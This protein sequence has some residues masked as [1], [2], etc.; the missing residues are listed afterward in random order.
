METRRFSLSA[1]PALPA[2]TSLCLGTFDGV[3]RGH[4]ALIRQAQSLSEGPVA[5]LLFDKSPAQFVRNGKS[6]SLLTTLADKLRLFA[7]LNV[8]FAY[9]LEVDRNFFALT[10]EAFIAQVLKPLKPASLVVGEDYAYG[11]GAKGGLEGLKD[12]FPLLVVPLLATETGKI[13]TQVIIHD[14]RSGRLGEAN[15]L[16]GR[17]YE[18]QGTVVRGLGN[19][20]KLGFPTANLA[21]TAPYVFPKD[22]V[23]EGLAYLRGQPYKALLNVGRNPTIGGVK[24]TR[25]ECHLLGLKETIYGETLYVDFLR[26]LREERKFSSLEALRAQMEKDLAA[27]FSPEKE[28]A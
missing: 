18:M 19:G 6:H 27:V 10:P 21:F 26:C 12:A 14:L 15:A 1:V 23:Y 11:A 9:V 25:I 3:H 7:A 17:P 13:S 4:V 22:G 5:V 8:D 2:K 16:L 20:R 24:K 28:Q